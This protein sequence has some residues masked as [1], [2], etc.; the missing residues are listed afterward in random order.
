[1]GRLG[2]L[3]QVGMDWTQIA[4]VKKMALAQLAR[5]R[6]GDIVEIGRASDPIVMKAA[7]D[8]LNEDPQIEMVPWDFQAKLSD[9]MLSLVWQAGA[10]MDSD[11]YGFLRQKGQM[12][13][14]E[15]SQMLRRMLAQAKDIAGPSDED[16]KAGKILGF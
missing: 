7:L 14:R 8:I 9:V 12:L 5:A 2:R 13:N 1:M 11:T 6:R 4:K 15:H 10:K 16:R 3:I